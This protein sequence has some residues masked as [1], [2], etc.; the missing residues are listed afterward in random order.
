[1]LLAAAAQAAEAPRYE[2]EF[3]DGHRVEG[4][5]ISAWH[6]D[7][8]QPKLEAVELLNPAHPLRWLKDRHPVVAARPEFG[9]GFVEMVGGDRLPGTVIGLDAG[10]VTYRVGNLVEPQ[11]LVRPDVALAAPNENVYEHVRVLV[12]FVRRVV[13]SDSPRADLQPGT[14]FLR[15]G[16]SATFRSVRWNRD[17]VRVL[18]SEGL[19][20]YD[21]RDLAELHLPAVDFWDSYRQELAILAPDNTA[22]I[23]RLQTTTGV[24][25]TGSNARGRVMNNGGS[26]DNWFHMLQPAWSLDPLW[27]PFTTIHTRAYFAPNEVP[28][29]RL[30]PSEVVQKS[31]LGG[32]WRWQLDRNAQRGPLVSG[33]LQHGWGIGVHA[34]SELSFI[35][36]ASARSF[37]TKIGI[38]QASGD[39]GCVRARVFVSTAGQAARQQLFESEHLVGSTRGVDTGD[40]ALPVGTAPLMLTL[41]ADPDHDQRPA[42]ADPL[43]IRDAVDWLEPLVTLDPEKLQTE[44]AAARATWIPAWNGWTVEPSGGEPL[45]LVNEWEKL[46]DSR[47]SYQ[48]AMQPGP[49]GAVLS[50][51]LQLNAE[52]RW[53]LLAVRRLSGAAAGSIFVRI[54]GQP[55]GEF[56]IPFFGKEMP[57]PLTVPIGKYAGR[58]VKFELEQRQAKKPEFVAWTAITVAS[59]L[60]TM[61]RMF[62]DD[63]R[64]LN[65]N[66]LPTGVAQLVDNDPYT[67]T[68][69]MRLSPAEGS[70]VTLDGQEIRIREKPEIGEFRY[71]RFAVRMTGQV[72]LGIECVP[73]IVDQ[74]VRKYD[75]GVGPPAMEGATRILRSAPTEWMVKTQDLYSNWGAYDLQEIKLFAVGE[76]EVLLDHVYLARSEADFNDIGAQDLLRLQQKSEQAQWAAFQQAITKANAATVLIDVEGLHGSGVLVT[77]DGFIATTGFA[78]VTPGKEAKIALADGRTVPAITLGIDRD[79]DAALLKIT[80]E[81][82]YPFLEIGNSQRLPDDGRLATVAF[83]GALPRESKLGAALVRYRTADKDGLW[84]SLMFDRSFSGG[85]LVDREGQLIGLVS[86]P[87]GPGGTLALTMHQFKASR[88]KLSH[89]KVWGDWPLAVTPHIGLNVGRR[90]DKLKV[91]GVAAA[92]PAARAGVKLE[93]ELNTFDGQ[94]VESVQDLLKL[95]AQKLPGEKASLQLTR[96]GKLQTVEITLERR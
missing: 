66:P 43:D 12:R 38:D 19:K 32:G 75:C 9:S 88:E 70:G 33:G 24:I 61:M 48:I 80:T 79:A 91:I 11:L 4:N 67:G 41:Q 2:A 3:V 16:R 36:P 78:A 90:D 57:K 17:E 56:E 10:E 21:Y 39:G 22:R 60:P 53:L 74:T 72:R 40:L 20:S 73:S 14:L 50:R 96:A 34:L 63:A 83:V 31:L 44:V 52:D 26:P 58:R 47:G 25:M 62:E 68:R 1:M 6:D 54:D 49:E 64:G 84:I 76:G 81:G 13:W 95:L 92:G 89:S 15:D 27:V 85:P 59:Q 23:V 55:A 93:D 86:R 51:E 71:L 5:T 42:G 77:K 8:A 69:C 82:E 46:P 7:N 37:R 18:T 94:P 45:V 65:P 29:S 35:L 30:Q 87:F 28:L